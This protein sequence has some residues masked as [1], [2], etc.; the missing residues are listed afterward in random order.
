M[1]GRRPQR[2]RIQSPVLLVVIAFCVI[3]LCV[4]ISCDL[5]AGWPGVVPE[6]VGGRLRTSEFEDSESR[7]PDGRKGRRVE[8]EEVFTGSSN[9]KV[10]IASKEIALRTRWGPLSAQV[11]RDGEA[12]DF[13]S[14]L[15]KELARYPSS[16]VESLSLD[17]LF[18]CGE[19]RFRGER[20]GALT[21]FEPRE[22]YFGA[23]GLAEADS[24]YSRRMVHHEF[25]HLLEHR[26]ESANYD[27]EWHSLNEEGFLYAQRI[28]H[29]SNCSLSKDVG[30][31]TEY[32]KS[33]VREDKAELFA[34][35]MTDVEY[36]RSRIGHDTVLRSKVHLMVERLRVIAPGLDV[37][38][39]PTQEVDPAGH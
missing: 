34:V 8:S 35:M 32:A 9:V 2:R 14:L 38:I 3:G 26:E 29:P 19:V 15:L 17:G 13:V 12:L 30:F 18:V 6:S 21:V 28:S 25:F 1:S 39:R 11:P 10:E 33:G 4:L 36:L 24:A 31:V 5:F 22:I 20:V 16:V 23:H 37:G 27:W 7:R